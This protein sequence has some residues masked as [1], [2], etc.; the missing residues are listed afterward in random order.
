MPEEQKTAQT[1]LNEIEN[2][3]TGKKA[4]IETVLN[5]QTNSLFKIEDIRFADCQIK[6]LLST[7]SSAQKNDEESETR[8]N[9]PARLK[10]KRISQLHELI[11]RALIDNP[12]ASTKELWSMIEQDSESDTPL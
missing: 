9:T 8:T 11:F 2:M 4:P 7:L 1:V 6:R 3:I 5:F 10:G 12:T